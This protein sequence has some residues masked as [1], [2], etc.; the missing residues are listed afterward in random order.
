M[1]NINSSKSSQFKSFG[2]HVGEIIT[3]IITT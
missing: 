2:K 1:N 3:I